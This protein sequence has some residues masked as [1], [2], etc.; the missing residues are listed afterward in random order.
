MIFT[1]RFLII[2]MVCYHVT[3]TSDDRFDPALLSLFDEIDGPEKITVIRES[4]R[5]H[6]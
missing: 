4:H 1:T 6:P 2:L 3:F 5:G